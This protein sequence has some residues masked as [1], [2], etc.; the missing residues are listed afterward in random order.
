MNTIATGVVVAW[1]NPLRDTDGSRNPAGSA[2]FLIRTN[3][4]DAMPHQSSSSA[5]SR[6]RFFLL[7]PAG[8]ICFLPRSVGC[9]SGDG[10]N[11]QAVSGTVTLDGQPLSGGNILFE[12]ATK[13]SGTAVG[14]TIRAGGLR[15]PE[16]SRAG[17]GLLPSAD[18]CQLND[19]GPSG[20]RTKRTDSAPDGRTAPPSLQYR[21]RVERRHYCRATESSSF[22]PEFQQLSRRPVTG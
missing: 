11:R 13:E 18:L 10:L 4:L 21:D 22:R 9:D 19:P 8:M 17:A 3:G 15:D 12:P 2:F 7:V 5:L 1:E 14:A 6:R 20:Q 16:E